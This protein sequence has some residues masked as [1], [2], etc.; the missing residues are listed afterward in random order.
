M[1]PWLF[2]ALISAIFAAL[3]NIFG[4]IGVADINSN[5]ATW[6]RIVV[7]FCVLTPM[8]LLRGEWLAPAQISSKTWVF[9]V[10]SGLATGASWLAYYRALQLGQA[11]L[12][13][14]IDKSSVLLVMLMGVVFLGEHLSLKQWA[15]AALIFTGVLIIAWPS[16]QTA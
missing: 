10:L 5:M 9:L 13:S 15:G 3:T 1:Q 2:Y 8:V 14:P 11:S 6:I 4:K 16:S 7:I 12:V